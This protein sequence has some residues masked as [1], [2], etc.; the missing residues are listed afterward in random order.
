MFIKCLKK[1]Y[2][3]N[4]SDR[5]MVIN[6]DHIISVEK[7]VKDGSATV[8]CTGKMGDEVLYYMLEDNFEEFVGRIMG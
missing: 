3:W 6:T 5:E 1:P 4:G 7:S 8:T 2:A